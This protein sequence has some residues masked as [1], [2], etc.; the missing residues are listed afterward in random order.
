M[1]ISPSEDFTLIEELDI[2]SSWINLVTFRWM[3]F[4]EDEC[5]YR[6]R[7][8]CR[9]TETKPD[10]LKNTCRNTWSCCLTSFLSPKPVSHSVVLFLTDQG[11]LAD[12]NQFFFDLNSEFHPRHLVSDVQSSIVNVHRS[13][14][15]HEIMMNNIG[16]YLGPS[17]DLGPFLHRLRI[18]GKKVC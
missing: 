14:K 7:L 2:C 12:I 18:E 13:G 11:L 3:L 16:K 9:R 15:L 6:G 1:P 8:P 17:P 5:H 10:C 4:S